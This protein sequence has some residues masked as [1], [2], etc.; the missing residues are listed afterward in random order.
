MNLHW[1]ASSCVRL[2]AYDDRCRELFIVFQSSPRIYVYCDVPREV[3]EEL[4]AAESKGRY[5]NRN[6][7]GV[8]RC[9]VE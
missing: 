6:V 7:R 1:A 5:V 3:F 2:F 8:Y 9:C 4:K